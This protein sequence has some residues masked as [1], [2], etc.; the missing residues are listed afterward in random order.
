ME[1]EDQMLRRLERSDDRIV[2]YSLG[3]D[4]SE[5]EYTQLMSE[6]R[7]AIALHGRVR[8]LFRLSD[9]SVSSFFTALDDRFSFVR[10]HQDEIERVAVVTDD[11]ATGWIARATEPIRQME[12]RT[13]ALDEEEQAWTWLE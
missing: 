13:F 2:G 12:T 3:G 10:D 11:R 7:D 4:V 5:N 9:V 8:I 6:L 1:G